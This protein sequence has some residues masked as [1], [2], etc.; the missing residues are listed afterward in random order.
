MTPRAL[1]RVALACSLVG[2]APMRASAAPVMFQFAHQMTGAPSNP[3]AGTLF[4]GSLVF[5]DFGTIFDA[6][7][8]PIFNLPDVAIVSPIL[9]ASVML[10][11][12]SYTLANANPGA[13]WHLQGTGFFGPVFSIQPA[14]LPAPLTALGL[15]LGGPGVFYTWT[16]ASGNSVPFATD[17]VPIPTGCLTSYTL[18]PASVPEPATLSL[19]LVGAAVAIGRRH[20]R[21]R[22]R[23]H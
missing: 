10:G 21:R 8:V 9:S 20:I 6:N 3:L 5:D 16:D 12:H 22:G 13:V 1:L 17:C 15:Y 19:L 2:F 14:L 7:G 11:P 4:F 23:S 18:L